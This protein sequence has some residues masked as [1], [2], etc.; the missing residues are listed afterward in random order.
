LRDT[1]GLTGTKYG[2]GISGN[3]GQA[4]Q[5]AW[6]AEQVPQCGYCKSGQ[7]MQATALLAKNP[8][9]TREQIDTA[10]TGNISRCA[11]YERI[12]RTI[13]RAA[14]ENV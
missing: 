14:K 9:R 7:I 8:H 4:V 10:I 2:C 1:L 3:T 5:H 11:T 6:M 12:R 13:Q